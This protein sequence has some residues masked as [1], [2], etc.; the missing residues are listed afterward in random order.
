MWMMWEI[1]RIQDVITFQRMFEVIGKI[2]IKGKFKIKSFRAGTQKFLRE[3]EWNEN[4]VVFNTTSG[5]NLV[6]E[7]LLG[8]GTLSLEV[9]KAKLGTGSTAAADANTDLQ[10]ATVDN[11]IIATEDI[12]ATNKITLTF[13]AP[14]ADVPNGTYNEVGIFVDS[15]DPRLFARAIISPAFT[16]ATNEDS[17]I[18]YTLTFDNT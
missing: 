11:I 13:F 12:T 7:A 2:G 10:T 17:Q 9:S 8:S 16:K 4:L 3:T 5:L 6:M 18:E 14:D 1:K 15:V